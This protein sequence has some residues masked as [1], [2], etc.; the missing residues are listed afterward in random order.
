MDGG[1]DDGNDGSD[2]DDDDAYMTQGKNMMDS[3]IQEEYGDEEYTQYY[4]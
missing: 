3:G 4:D 1:S 2:D